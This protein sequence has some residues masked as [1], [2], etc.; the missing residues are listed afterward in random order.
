MLADQKHLWFLLILKMTKYMSTDHA[1]V[2]DTSQLKKEN[3][4]RSDFTD[5]IGLVN[6]SFV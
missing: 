3:E 6:K 4:Y 1:K 5:D 2:N